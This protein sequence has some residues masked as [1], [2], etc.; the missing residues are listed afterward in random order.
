MLG[1]GRNEY[2]IAFLE[3]H[4]LALDLERPAA[5]EHDIELV[6]GVGAAGGRAPAR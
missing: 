2:R 6:V 4:L 3:R 1:A 5:L